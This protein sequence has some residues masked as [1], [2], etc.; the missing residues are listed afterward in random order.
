MKHQVHLWTKMAEAPGIKSLDNPDARVVLIKEY[1][2]W[3]DVRKLGWFVHPFPVL[4]CLLGDPGK[5]L[6][7]IITGKGDNPRCRV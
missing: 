4:V 2:P 7:A 6:C 3:S 1:V 5:S